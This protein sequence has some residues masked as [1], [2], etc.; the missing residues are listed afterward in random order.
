MIK[1]LVIDQPGV[2]AVSWWRFFRPFAEM[3][4]QH[5]GRFDFSF[6]RNLEPP[7]LFGSDVVILS[8]PNDQKTLDYVKRAKDIG[9][10][11]IIY[12]LDD[13]ITNLPFYHDQFVYHRNRTNI[14]HQLFELSDLFW[15][16]TDA[17]RYEVGDLNRAM[18]VPNAVYEWDLPHEASPDRGLWMWRGKGMQKE[19]VYQAGVEV[20]EQIKAKPRR[21]VFWGCLPNIGHLDNVIVEEYDTDTQS[22][23]AKLKNARFNG[24]WKPLVE[25]HFN[26]CKSN[27][28]WIEATMSGGVCLTNYAGKL[29][30]ENAVSEFPTYDEAV[31]VW[32]KSRD[33]IV[34]DFNLVNTARQRAESIEALLNDRPVRF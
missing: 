25:C 13:A 14:A 32:S 30:W 20:Y 11:K 1:C 2:N 31:E 4:R 3:K 33:R 27:I 23:F 18:V 28:S 15:V 9:L 24:V 16:S 19:D 34:Q 5:P 10:S 6:K 29:A 8:R 17:L 22:Y 26:D 21:W 7:D 12:D